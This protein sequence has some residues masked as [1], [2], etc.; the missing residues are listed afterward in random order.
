MR[1]GGL[2]RSA[3]DG[4]APV[5]ALVW[6]PAPTR[7]RRYTARARDEVCDCVGDVV[8]PERLNRA[9]LAFSLPDAGAQMNHDFSVHGAGT[10]PD[11]H[12]S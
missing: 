4:V 6:T 1:S 2:G 9:D 5:E 10:G 8:A 12:R 7:T 3:R 11:R